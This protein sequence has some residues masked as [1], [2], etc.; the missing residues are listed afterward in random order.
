[1]HSG[2]VHVK[3][4]GT[5]YLEALKVVA[6]KE[7]SLFREILDYSAGLYEVEKKSYHVSAD[8]KKVKKA[9]EYNDKELK[10]LFNINDIRQILHV[11]YGRVL[12]D[13][14][15]SGKYLFREN[16]YK[17]LIENEDLHYEYLITHFH[18]HLDPFTN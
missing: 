3:T 6:S 14:N 4:A 7:T 11:T 2:Y 1:M 10:E 16:I 5:S 18:R 8:I 12:T 15:D 9:S 13:K 17:C